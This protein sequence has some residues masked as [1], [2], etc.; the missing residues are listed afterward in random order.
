M[1]KTFILL[2]LIAGLSNSYAAESLIKNGKLKSETISAREWTSKGKS[3]SAEGTGQE[4]SVKNIIGEGDFTI[5]ADLTLEKLNGSAASFMLGSGHFIFDG[6]GEKFVLEGGDFPNGDIGSSKGIITPGKEFKFTVERNS[7][8]L[9]FSIDDKKIKSFTYTKGIIHTFGFRPHRNK[10]SLRNVVFD[11]DLKDFAKLDYVFA[12]GDDGY[13][14]YRI[15]SIIK[16]KKGT[17]LASCEGRVNHSGDS[18]NI[19]LVLKRSTDNGKTWSKIKVIR[20]IK[21]TAG[22]PCPVVDQETGRITMVFCEMDHHEGHVIAGKSDRRVFT[23]YSDN[24]GVTWSRPIKITKSVN[25]GGKYNWLAAGPGISIQIQKGKYK[26]RLVVPFANTI[27]HDFGVHTIYSDDKGETWKASNNITGGCNESQLVELSNGDLM[28]NMRMQTHSK[29]YRG[30]S[31]SKDGGE[32][33]SELEHDDEL[34][35]PRCQG[36]IITHQGDKKR[37]LIFSNPATGGRNGMTIQVSAN[38]GKTWPVEKLI[39]PLSSGYSNVVV[40]DDDHVLCLFE[41][42][43]ANYSLSGI[44]S[45]RMPLAELKIK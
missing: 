23:M 12:C 38:D 40:T 35:D 39:Y 43:P 29:G 4:L 45:I 5:E 1:K 7:N 33:W 21:Q 14:S 20:D 44:A 36:S 37:Y 11:G 41:G 31:F 10:M 15:P 42:G 25:P 24:D 19:D 17:L 3:I 30:L 32:T 18:G 26:G 16:T 6:R 28:L 9:I 2:S 8:M 34:K 22:N 27:G 13:K